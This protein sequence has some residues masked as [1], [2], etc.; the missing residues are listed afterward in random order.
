MIPPAVIAGHI[1][2]VGLLMISRLPTYSFKQL[3]IDRG[4]ARYFLLGAGLIAAALLTYLWATLALMTLAYIGTLVW[5]FRSAR[6]SGS[7]ED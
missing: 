2:L 4:N 5:A 7:P 3:S 1:C 6:K